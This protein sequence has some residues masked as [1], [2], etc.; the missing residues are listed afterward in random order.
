[1][2][3]MSP[4]ETGPDRDG[5]RPHRTAEESPSASPGAAD[6]SG[7]RGRRRGRALG[8]D[9]AA[10]LPGSAA[11]GTRWRPAS[12]AEPVPELAGQRARSRGGVAEAGDD[13]ADHLVA[14]GEQGGDGAGG[15][16]APPILHMAAAS[17]ARSVRA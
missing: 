13:R 11:S 4:T 5:I 10:E 3:A 9:L 8:E 17:A 1:M 14:Q 16:W 7:H 12:T 6:R 15:G 2:A